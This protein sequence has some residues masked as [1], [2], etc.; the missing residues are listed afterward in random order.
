MSDYKEEE[1]F[2]KGMENARKTGEP[3]FTAYQKQ[4]LND[5]PKLAISFD[6]IEMTHQRIKSS[7]M[8]LSIN[9]PSRFQRFKSSCISFFK[10][11]FGIKD[12]TVKVYMHKNRP[13]KS[14]A[15]NIQIGLNK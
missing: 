2:M 13:K 14:G 12:S 7:D 9:S 8:I 15:V 1:D 4:I 6:D 5:V 3:Y 11:L 10:R